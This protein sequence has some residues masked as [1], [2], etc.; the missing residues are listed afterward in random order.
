MFGQLIFA[1]I[2]FADHV[3]MPTLDSGWHEV[4][5]DDCKLPGWNAQPSRTATSQCLIGP[6]Q[7]GA[8]LN[9]LQRDS[10][11]R[12]GVYGQVRRGAGKRHARVH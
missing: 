10:R 6:K 11:R 12:Q 8:V 3:W 4:E 1:D 2:P 9:E 7:T 5:K